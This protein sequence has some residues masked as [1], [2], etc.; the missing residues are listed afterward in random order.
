M[1]DAYDRLE[2]A[3]ETVAQRAEWERSN[4][5]GLLWVHA[6]VGMIAGAQML[7]YGSAATIEEAVG[8]WTRLA[9]G[10]LGI[11]GG[12]VLAFGILR[13]RTVLLEAIGLAAIG[14]WD[15]LMAAGF[16]YARV[17]G[18]TFTPRALFEPIPTGYVLPYPIS[19]Y[20]G[21]AALI[22]VHLWTLRRFKRGR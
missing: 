18:G 16:A 1:P 2:Q 10:L 12:I 19:V 15:L 21:L 13:G 7:L 6:A 22:T 4:R 14:I 9:L 8:V 17:G 3:A 20:I 11:I 5:V